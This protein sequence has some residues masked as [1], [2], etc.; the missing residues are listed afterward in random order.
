MRTRALAGFLTQ[1]QA[2]A[3]R[4]VKP[5]TDSDRVRAF[6]AAVPIDRYFT[7]REIAEASGLSLSRVNG[8]VNNLVQQRRVAR[9]YPTRM[10]QFGSGRPGQMYRWTS[11]RTAS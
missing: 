3:P 9:R 1:R 11:E 8:A 10:G 5:P 6:F 2:S 7:L 4:P